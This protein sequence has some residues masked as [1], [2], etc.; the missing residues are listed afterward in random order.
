MFSLLLN[1]FSAMSEAEG[2]CWLVLDGLV[3]PGIFIMA[4]YISFNLNEINTSSMPY[5]S[6]SQS[7]LLCISCTGVTDPNHNQHLIRD[8]TNQLCL[9]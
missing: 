3:T 2:L 9:N 8:L 5:F 7:F 1:Q 6:V 4:F